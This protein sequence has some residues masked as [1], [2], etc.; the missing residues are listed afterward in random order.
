[1]IV[2]RLVD[3]AVMPDLLAIETAAALS[4]AAGDDAAAVFV[5]VGRRRHPGRR[6]T[7][8]CDAE[9]ARALA[10]SA[11]Q[12]GAT[13]AGGQVVVEPLGHD[14]DDE[15]LALVASSA[16]ARPADDAAPADDRRPSRARGS[17]CAARATG[18]R[19]RGTARR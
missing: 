19:S 14:G 11:L 17:R 7:A 5:R 16:P 12:V 10:R 4:E 8:A 13:D 18:P 9:A 1:M 15:R 6:A 2:R 3:A